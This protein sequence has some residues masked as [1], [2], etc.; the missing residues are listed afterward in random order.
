MT[1]ELGAR[2]KRFKRILL[3]FAVGIC[4]VIAGWI[5][6]LANR[7]PEHDRPTTPELMGGPP[8][9]ADVT[10]DC[11]LKFIYRNGE[12]AKQ[13]TIL[14][15]LGGGVALIDYDGDGLLDVFVTGGGYFDGPDKQS[16][17]GYPCKLFRNLGH[18]KFRDVS[19]EAGF[20]GPWFYS[21]GA[22]VADYDRD[23]WPDLLVTGYG[24]LELYHNEPDGKG[25]RR[26]V[27]VAQKLRLRDDSWTTSAGWADLD[28]D[29]F[30]DIYVCHYVNW[31]FANNP[32]CQA[33]RE[34]I[35]RDVC[36]PQR[37]KPLVHGLFHNDG[38]KSFRDVSNEQQ[39]Q[40]VG[41]GLGVVLV[42]LDD[43]GKPDVFVANDA[44]NRLLFMNRGGKLRPDRTRELLLV[45]RGMEAGVAV[46]EAGSYEGSMGVDAG[47]YDGSGRA[48]LWVTNFHGDIHG[49]FL[50][51][52][53]N[54]SYQSR[55][56]GLVAIGLQWVGFGTGFIDFDNDGWEDIVIANGHVLY[57]PKDSEITAT[58][59]QR[60][61]LL[62]NIEHGRRYF[63][64]ISSQAGPFFAIP[65]IGRGLAIGDLDNDGW[66]DIVVSHTNSPVA[67]LRNEAVASK[68]RWL[69]VQ[70]AGRDHR[71]IVGS[72]IVLEGNTRK[73][74]RFAK[75]GGSYLSS[76]DRRILFGLGESEQVK[77]VTVKWSWGETQ[78]WDNLEPNSYWE[79][80]EGEAA[81]KK[82]VY[83][84]H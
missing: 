26:F 39:F 74:T 59:R 20:D 45:E 72:T 42:D 70:L 9:F 83:P 75:G 17:K 84:G 32:V 36:P 11:G 16:I 33:Y 38:G 14:E 51:L 27:P 10:P 22:A 5:I 82:L 67:L 12:E 61:I 44:T 40:A 63:K 4:A 19:E 65:T 68:N 30:P 31:S 66:P 13:F 2:R 28:G 41:C 81:A 35:E 79:L 56:A 47:D 24:R 25:G 62:H 58:F 80:R 6:W 76:G 77:R 53:G 57:Y 52:G 46:N 64:D 69:G 15:S 71:D 3:A 34:G 18:W 60:P 37:F 55:A 1:M 8:L 7:T 50:N 21:H 49:L 23:G 29:G 54:F 73:L 48:S 78:S 43:D